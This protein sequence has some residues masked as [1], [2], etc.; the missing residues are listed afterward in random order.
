M[1]GYRI[2]GDVNLTPFR[3]VEAE[4]YYLDTARL[5]KQ[6]VDTPIIL[7]GGIKSF[8]VAERIIQNGDADYIGLCRPLIRE[9]DLVNRWK[10]GDTSQS[11][12]IDDNAC[13]L[14]NGELK[15]P[16]IL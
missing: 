4:G 12:C 2:R 7:T 11:L 14:R 6:A 3:N 16:Q 15:C 13:V 10:S 5:M 1:W 9:P 8:E